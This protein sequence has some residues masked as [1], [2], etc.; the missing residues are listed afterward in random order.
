MQLIHLI[1]NLNGHSVKPSTLN[2]KHSSNL[3][4]CS[5]KPST[6]NVK[7]LLPSD[8]YAVLVE[9]ASE[10]PSIYAVVACKLLGAADELLDVLCLGV[11]V[12]PTYLG[13]G[14]QAWQC[15]VLQLHGGRHILGP[16]VAL[17]TQYVFVLILGKLV[18]WVE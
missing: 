17:Y 1:N 11:G 2:V 10:T 6:L 13:Y 4:D 9:V 7:H 5:V 8:L 15:L 16:Q 12:A 3:N 14:A 18:V